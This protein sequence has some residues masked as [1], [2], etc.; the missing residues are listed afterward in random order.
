MPSLKRKGIVLYVLYF[1]ILTSHG[2]M[3]T[4]NERA[5]TTEIIST[6][7]CAFYMQ[8]IECFKS[9]NVTI[10]ATLKWYNGEVVVFSSF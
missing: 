6:K 10:K 1:S 3:K 9:I 2:A 7:K 4:L 5:E 8:P